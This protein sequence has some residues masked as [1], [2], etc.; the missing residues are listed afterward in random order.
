MVAGFVEEYVIAVVVFLED[1]RPLCSRIGGNVRQ[2]E[3]PAVLQ[4]ELHICCSGHCSVEVG[5]K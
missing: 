3:L 1:L 2:V 4:R 5:G